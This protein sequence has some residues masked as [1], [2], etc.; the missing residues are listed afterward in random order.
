MQYDV[1]GARRLATMP[2]RF[3]PVKVLLASFALSS[4]GGL[5]ALLRSNQP[6]GW[7]NVLATLLYSGVTGL[8]I[9][10]LWYNYFDGKGNIYFLLGVSG[11]AGIGGMTVIDFFV[12]VLRKG[13]VHISINPGRAPAEKPVSPQAKK[14][15]KDK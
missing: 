11:L 5:A 9:A 14:N 12:Q 10:L 13:G 2:D 8:T 15:K 4:L 3:D 7:R 1:P 6:L